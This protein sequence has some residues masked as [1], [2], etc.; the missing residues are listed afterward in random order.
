[1]DTTKHRAT[2]QKKP[3]RVSRKQAAY[4]GMMK[5][6]K[7]KGFFTVWGYHIVIGLFIF[8]CVAAVLFVLS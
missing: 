1:M 7:S 5:K 4:E 6:N 8:V 2:E 3:K